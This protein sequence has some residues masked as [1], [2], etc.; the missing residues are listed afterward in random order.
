[1]HTDNRRYSV[2]NNR[3]GSA[4]VLLAGL[5]LGTVLYMV[6]TGI[7]GPDSRAAA[8]DTMQASSRIY[9]NADSLS[10]GAPLADDNIATT[11]PYGEDGFRL[12]IGVENHSQQPLSVDGQPEWAAQTDSG[13]R[14]WSAVASSNDGARLTAVASGD[15]IYT[16]DDSGI[17]WTQ[18]IASG[19]RNWSAIASSTDGTKLAAADL[20]GYIYTS[21][22]SGITWT[23]RVGSG[24]RSWRS[25]TISDDGAKLAAVVNSGY[26]YTS[27]NSGA[28]WTQRANSRTWYSIDGTADGAKLVAT[29]RNDY[30]Y[31]STDFGATWV[32]RT[33]SAVGYWFGATIS[34]DG[35]KIAAVDNNNGA[36]GY[37]WTSVD[38]G[39][40]WAQR[41]SSGARN[42]YGIAGSSDGTYLIAADKGGYVYVS[43]DGG[44]TWSA[45]TGVGQDR[46]ASVAISGDGTTT[47]SATDQ[48]G[49]V[50][51]GRATTQFTP[52]LQF[53]AMTAGACSVQTLGWTDVTGSSLIRYNPN[54]S[55]PSGSVIAATSTDP[56]ANAGYSYA[57]QTYASDSVGLTIVSNIGPAHTGLWDVSLTVST[58]APSGNYCF[59]IV[60]GD[61]PLIEYKNY[62]EITV[63]PIVIDNPISGDMPTHSVDG[64]IG[65]P[66]T[67]LQSR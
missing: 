38:G 55:V 18:Q 25:V 1:M 57:Y 30:I 66:N 9:V 7:S 26:I 41:T 43:T 6:V 64:S 48:N 53:V 36:G 58:D 62:P 17:T 56:L 37:V 59:R 47:L 13:V 52:N 49:Y 5:V 20:G 34:D 42:W 27:T 60:N 39:A 4:A 51:T 24:A 65:V 63:K 32:K 28:A 3:Y 31:T 67:G 12:R 19:V 8:G 21:T 11:V 44:V 33:S 35:S 15:Y 10:P 40:T 29:V 2:A 61:T 45:Q 50:Y 54:P 46:W 22:D 16:S 14:N 23:Q